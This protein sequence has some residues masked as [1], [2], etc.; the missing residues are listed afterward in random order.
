M[1]SLNVHVKLAE[2]LVLFIKEIKNK[3][4][5]LIANNNNRIENKQ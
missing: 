4:Q 2:K 1:L 3:S 5:K